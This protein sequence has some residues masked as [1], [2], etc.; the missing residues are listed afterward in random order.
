MTTSAGNRTSSGYTSLNHVDQ[1]LNLRSMNSFYRALTVV[2]NIQNYW[3][4][5]LCPSSGI[6]E[7][8][9]KQRFGKPDLIPF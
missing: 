7:I 8:R 3:V 6:L 2:Y 1:F 5:G 4:F 9:K